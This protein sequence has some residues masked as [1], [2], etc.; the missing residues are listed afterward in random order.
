MQELSDDL[1]VLGEQLLST[2]LSTAATALEAVTKLKGRGSTRLLTD[3]L[4][5]APEGLLTTRAA[6]AL[7][8]RKHKSCLP[9]IYEVYKTRPELAEDIIPILSALEDPE[10]VALVADDLDELIAGS[11]RLSTIA[12]LVKCADPEAITDAFL[13]RIILDRVPGAQDDLRWGLDQ[14]LR[15]ADEDT[16]THAKETATELGPDAV[17]IIEP[18]MPA[19]GELEIQAPRLARS[20]IDELE[21]QELLEL[22]PDSDD[23]LVDVL[24]N[25]IMEARSPKGLIRDVERIL[26]N[27]TAIEEIYADRKDLMKV[28]SK[29][30]NQ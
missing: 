25:T 8:N 22:V 6:I 5:T 27:S 21:A 7:E 16:L 26:M 19:V 24:A 17:A 2:N 15:D 30:A 23:A 12:Y 13:I 9:G 10:G 28:F 20:L 18:Y 4:L 11:A 14:L 3:F 1:E 29:I